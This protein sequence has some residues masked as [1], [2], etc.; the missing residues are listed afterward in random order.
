MK[1][2]LSVSGIRCAGIACGIKKRRKDLALIFSE[3][4]CE[5]AGV[6]TQNRLKAAPVVINQRKQN[7][8]VQAIV[9]NSGNA[10]SATG[11]RG[12]ED[13]EAMCR[14]TAESLG[15][16]EDSVLVASTGSI[17]E[18]LPMRKIEAGIKRLT[19]ALSRGKSKDCARAIMTTDSFSKEAE[20][21]LGEFRIAGIAKGAGMIAPNLATMLA[22][23]VTDAKVERAELKAVLKDVVDQTFN[24]ITVDGD[25]STNDMVIIMA[26]RLCNRPDLA[27]FREVLFA[28][29]SELARKII[30][31]AEGAT[32]LIRVKVTGARYREDADRVAR[33]VAE[34]LLVKCSIFGKKPNPGRILCAC[35]YSGADISP[36]RID[37]WIDGVLVVKSGVVLKFCDRSVLK[38]RDIEI[39]IDLGEGAESAI[40]FTSDIS[41]E[42]VRMN[43][44]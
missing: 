2:L 5:W 6:F 20:M 23:I 35:G 42:Y 17:G 26:N 37:I 8:K 33:S 11:E 16:S 43:A 4:P 34:S 19:K 22:F 36:E 31:D 1:G 21:D 9:I 18:P 12:L 32:R 25:T 40:F 38:D 13:A 44:R 41:P 24:R 14:M 10:N 3:S 29:C 28:V 7:N 27:R 15:I 39:R 30:E